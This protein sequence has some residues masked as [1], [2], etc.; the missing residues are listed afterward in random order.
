MQIEPIFPQAVLGLNTIEVNSDKVLNY[1]KNIEFETTPSSIRNESLCY[2]SKSKKIFENIPY[3]EDEIFKNIKNYLN[4]I[5]KLKM[6]FQFTTSWVSKTPPQGI[7][8]KHLHSNSFLSGVYYP[9]G[10]KN[11][12][13]RFYKKN[14]FWDI[15][16]T[17]N[18]I[19]NADWYSFNIFKDNTL[20]LFPSHLEHS[21]EKNLSDKTRYSIAFNTLPLGEIGVGDSKINFK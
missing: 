9:K 17:E 1:I 14:N 18:N 8:Q 4:N 20:I 6:N 19:L 2:I 7:S 5:M 10:N 21:I 16:K 3:L 12:N 13:I 11:F 15:E